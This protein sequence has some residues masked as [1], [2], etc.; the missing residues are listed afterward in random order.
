MRSMWDRGSDDSTPR[1]R[2]TSGDTVNDSRREVVSPAAGVAQ[3]LCLEQIGFAASQLLFG[4]LAFV[5]VR[6]EV[7]PA[8]NPALAIP[9]RQSA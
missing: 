5:D 2:S 1:I 7:V 6:Q 3:P 9:K 8:N 4:L